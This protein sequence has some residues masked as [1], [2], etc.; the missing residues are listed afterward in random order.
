MSYKERIF[1]AVLFEVIAL[2]LAIVLGSYITGKDTVSMGG[3]VVI[4]SV[5][6]MVWNYI[7]NWGIDH[8]LQI[9]RDQRGLK[10]RILHSLGF[11]C[12]LIF[13]SVPFL[14][15]ALDMPFLQVLLLDIGG[16]VFFLVY[17]LVFNWAYD[18]FLG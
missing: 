13:V 18:R 14:M 5:C 10:F 15:W 6:A 11:E 1:H 12:G 4:L 2:L 9:E 8:Y 17:S 7:Y 3:I 16:V